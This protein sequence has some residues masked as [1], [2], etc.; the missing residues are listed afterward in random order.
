VG[1]FVYPAITP[2]RYEKGQDD[3]ATQAQ[4]NRRESEVVL[5]HPFA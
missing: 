3:A 2:P 5:Q 1:S 4:A